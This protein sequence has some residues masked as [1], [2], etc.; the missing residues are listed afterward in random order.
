MSYLTRS[1]PLIALTSVA[2]TGCNED[3]TSRGASVTPT[4]SGGSS[5]GQ[6]IEQVVRSFCAA[7][8][9][10]VNREA[11]YSITIAECEEEGFDYLDAAAL[12][13]ADCL[14]ATIEYY[15]CLT[16]FGQCT[17]YAD[18]DD[19]YYS[20]ESGVNCLTQLERIY[21]NC[22]YYSYSIG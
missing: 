9:P 14:N 16:Q 2:V 5:A 15:S 10:C 19:L 18:D 1:I 20:L 3:P 21:D 11:G 6:D 17:P 8:V 22:D 13:G 4:P 7:Y 12:D